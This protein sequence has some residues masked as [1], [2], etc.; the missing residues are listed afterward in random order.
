MK[1]LK[2]QHLLSYK[3][4]S[5]YSI[6]LIALGII[7]LLS[8]T[9]F[10][11]VT[12]SL[13]LADVISMAMQQN[14]SLQLVHHQ[15]Q[16]ADNNAHPGAAGMLPTVA[17]FGSTSYGLSN[18][19][20][21]ILGNS[22]INE[23]NGAES[24]TNTGGVQL[25][26]TLFNGLGN[27]RRYQQLKTTH[28]AAQMNEHMVVEKLILQVTQAYYNVHRTQQSKQIAVAALDISLRRA[29]TA[30]RAV[31][32]GGKNRLSLLNAQVDVQNDSIYLLQTALEVSKATI[33]L[34]TLL[35][36]PPDSLLVFERINVVDM[37][38]SM[39]VYDSLKTTIAQQNKELLTARL[40]EQSSLLN[41][42]IARS[43]FL[44]RI[45]LESSYVFTDAQSESSIFAL[46]QSNVLNVGLSVSM[47]LYM[48]NTRKR[49]VQNASL[50]QQS[51]QLQYEQ[52][53]LRVQG[54]LYTANQNYQ[55]S[56]QA[57]QL[58]QRTL[59]TIEQNLHQSERLHQVGQIN[60]TQFREA[61]L[62]WVRAK[63]QLNNQ[64]YNMKL[65]TLELLR[66]AGKLVEVDE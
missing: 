47:P 4:R 39:L 25:T 7:S 28:E 61:Q 57:V 44:P 48:G 56:M 3:M 8:S 5:M 34:N 22:T 62:N 54:E 36:L 2:K 45:E 21:Q 49:T 35:N 15:T 16:I 59:S 42:Q 40:N 52:L 18:S 66:L 37:P 24:N 50:Q 26:Y 58:Q 27:Y 14:T 53:L 6:R 12:D 20:N 41:L 60:S 51:T 65:A 32:Y 63:N 19:K 38:A 1:P 29:Q 31:E 55:H 64:V 13:S 23:F 17:L 30:Q 43:T 11:R 33:Q 46:N 9:T 10:A